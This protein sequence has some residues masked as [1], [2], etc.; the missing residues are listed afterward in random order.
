MRFVVVP[1]LLVAM[2]AQTFTQG[3]YYLDYIINK[4]SYEEHCINKAKTW[5]HCDGKCQLAK[6][7]IESEKRQ[8]NAPEMKL[9][10]KT[11]VLSSRSF[12]TNSITITYATR[13]NRHIA[14]VIGGP[15]DQPSFFFHPPGAFQL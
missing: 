11:E 12:Y 2:L 6:K 8:Q 10:A 15:V 1:I 13:N 14:P 5:L 3:F 4:A 7:I 9:A